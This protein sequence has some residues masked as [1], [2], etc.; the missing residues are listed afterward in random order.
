MQSGWAR[1][2][3][4]VIALLIMNVAFYVIELVLMRA[5][6]PVAEYTFL[7]PGRVFDEGWVWLPFTYVLFHAPDQPGHLL[8]NL[9]MLWM[10]GAAL[11]SWWGGKRLVVGYIV[12]ALA[13]SAFT[14]I[15]ALLSQTPLLAWLVPNFWSGPHVGASGAVVGLTLAWGFVFADQDMGFLF[16]G[17]MKGKTF[18][19]IILGVELLV[20]LS[21]DRTSSTSHLGGMLG[22][23][24]LIKG[25]WRPSRW[26]DVFR[27]SRLNRKKK[28][29]ERE[30]R[31]L[32][33]GKKDDLPN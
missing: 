21:F 32:E 20:A 3:R 29:I 6:A 25:L 15:I 19:M 13:G 8:F 14:L 16:L 17:R 28:K 23:F 7:V 30:L 31:V 27:K 26:A 5:G 12:C 4:A 10:F 24:I 11:E 22:A 1:P 9:L 18:A 33:G 2:G